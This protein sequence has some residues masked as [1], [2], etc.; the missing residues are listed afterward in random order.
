MVTIIDKIQ[1]DANNQI[2]FIQVGYTSDINLINEINKNYDSTLGKFI[3]ENRTDLENNN[4]K[5]SV[6]FENISEVFEAR[7]M[8]EKIDE[9]NLIEIT[10]INQL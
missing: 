9:I 2:E 8:T 7:N 4:L 10:N 3:A 1:I 5:I 6:F